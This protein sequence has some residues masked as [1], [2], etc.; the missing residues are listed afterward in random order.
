MMGSGLSAYEFLQNSLCMLCGQSGMEFVN[1]IRDDVIRV[2][3]KC[4]HCSHVQLTPL[5]SVEEDEEYY[6]KDRMQKDTYKDVATLQTEEQ[7][8]Y[9]VELFVREQASTLIKF[10]PDSKDI[11]ILE[12]GS[13]FG[14][15]PQLMR[16]EGYIMDG[17]EINDEKRELC[18]KRCDIALHG[19]N[20]LYDVP[21]SIEKQE[22]YDVI[23]LMHT[24]EHISD[25][26]TFLERASIL[27]KPNGMIYIDSPNLN[28]W[29]KEQQQEYNNW[30]FMRTHVSYFTPDIMA[31]LLKDCGFNHIETYGHQAYSIENALH[32]FR[33]KKPNLL[34]HQLYLPEP[35]EWIN[36]I[37]KEKVERELK[38]GFFVCIGYK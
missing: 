34:E 5:P 14:W 25:P 38:S 11:K 2:A 35:L 12:I 19:W 31:G 22:Y 29:L 1:R 27:L 33:N 20:F 28:D 24:L 8:M 16:E 6:K 13:G 7:L 4:N 18:K 30:T 9:R 26:K 32:W 23:C 37:Y 36:S 10:L 17:I 3:A 15:L 21:E